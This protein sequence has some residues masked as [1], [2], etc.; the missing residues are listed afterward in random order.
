MKICRVN[1]DVFI[2]FSV[3]RVLSSW[4][5]RTTFGG[6][7]FSIALNLL[8]ATQSLTLSPSLRPVD[9]KEM[10]FAVR[11]KFECVNL[12]QR[13]RSES[14]NF[15]AIKAGYRYVVPARIR[16]ARCWRVGFVNPDTFANAYAGPENK[17]QQ[18]VGPRQKAMD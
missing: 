6:D 5:S 8:L 16:S 14:S 10:T 4:K 15:G 2:G 11:A 7:G 13:M 17:K 12:C 9:C 3:T 18:T 1:A